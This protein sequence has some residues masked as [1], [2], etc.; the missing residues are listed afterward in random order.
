VNVGSVFAG[1]GGFDLGLERAGMRTA[2]QIEINPF[3]RSR[4]ALRFPCAKQFGDVR[5]LT[6]RDLEPVDLLC[7]GFPCQ[8]AS[9]AAR[10]R[11]CAPWLWPELARLFREIRPSYLVMENVEA[12]LYR[13]RGFG[14]VLGDLAE[15]GFDATWRV[16]RASDF[17]APHHRA[18]VWL[19]GY[20]HGDGKPDLTLDAKASRVPQLRGSVWSWSDRP[21]GL[22]VADGLPDRM[23][24]VRALGESIVPQIPEW[25]G[26]LILKRERIGMSTSE[27]QH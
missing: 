16:L 21:E 18:R 9:Q 10:G 25:I 26:G 15:S 20:P 6:A 24:R 19:V 17:G 13:G 11:N 22:G 12:L 8:S 2:W 7:G 3:R 1:L 23:E 4:L 5:D 14:E 27:G